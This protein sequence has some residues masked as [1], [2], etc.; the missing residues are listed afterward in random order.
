MGME[1]CQGTNSTSGYELLVNIA[2][3]YSH[4]Q[5]EPIAKF[6][7]RKALFLTSPQH[8]GREQIFLLS[9]LDTLSQASS[10]PSSGQV[11]M[12]YIR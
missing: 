10:A 8:I 9:S 5:S 1:N 3:L 2:I 11:P 4:V 12:T 6:V 7:V